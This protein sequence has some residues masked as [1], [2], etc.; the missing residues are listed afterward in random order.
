MMAFWPNR[1]AG[2]RPMA[3]YFLYKR[4]EFMSFLGCAAAAWLIAVRA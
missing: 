1:D 4:R 2:N 3:S